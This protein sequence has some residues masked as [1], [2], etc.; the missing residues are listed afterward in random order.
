MSLNKFRAP[1]GY[2]GLVSCFFR[3]LGTSS[4]A[5]AEQTRPSESRR[6]H[7]VTKQI[8]P[9]VFFSFFLAVAVD[10]NITVK[11]AALSPS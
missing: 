3:S 9:A 10:A 6:H 5:R 2:R 1:L 7:Y 4:G 11:E 8:V